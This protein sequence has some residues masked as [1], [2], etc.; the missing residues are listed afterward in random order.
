MI[1]SLTED[2]VMYIILSNLSH[3]CLVSGKCW[4]RIYLLCVQD[5]GRHSYREMERDY[6]N[7]YNIIYFILSFF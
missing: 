5:T 7:I 1:A 3:L 6:I 4:L 2:P